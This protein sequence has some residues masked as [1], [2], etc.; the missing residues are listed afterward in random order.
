[1]INKLSIL[2][3]FISATLYGQWALWGNPSLPGGNSNKGLGANKGELYYSLVQSNQ[4][5][6]WW[7]DPV[8]GE[9]FMHEGN[10]ITFILSPGINIKKSKFKKLLIKHKKKL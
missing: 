5:I 1:M 6:G 8:P 3:L 9:D 4:H 10:L 2:L 7:H